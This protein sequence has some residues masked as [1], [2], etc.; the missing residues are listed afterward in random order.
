MPGCLGVSVGYAS[1]F[2]SGHDLTACEFKP[3]VGLCADSPEPGACFGFCVSLSLSLP[4]PCSWSVALS[5][6]LSLSNKHKKCL[7]T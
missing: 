1:N 2:S 7:Q 4:L 5:H 6:S 3:H